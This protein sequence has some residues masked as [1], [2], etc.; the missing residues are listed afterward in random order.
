VRGGR[1]T[2][3]CGCLLETLA[4]VTRARQRELEFRVAPA[5][6]FESNAL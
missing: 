6:E 5:A 1:F 4:V 2:T 3:V